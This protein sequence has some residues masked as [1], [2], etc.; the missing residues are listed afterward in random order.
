MMRITLTCLIVLLLAACFKYPVHQGNV[1][2]PEELVQVR[3]GDSRYYV[4]RVLGTPVLKDVLHPRRATYIEDR[5][6][7]K[8]D[9]V[10]RR[11]VEIEYNDADV[12]ISIGRE[13]F[14]DGEAPR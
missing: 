5:V 12:V 8:E 3:M 10:F 4:E 13:G 6:D 7:D 11:R 2:K 1:I 14:D 9:K